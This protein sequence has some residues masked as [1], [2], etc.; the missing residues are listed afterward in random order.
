MPHALRLSVFRRLLPVLALLFSA[1]P[2]LTQTFP[3][4]PA[5]PP[6]NLQ[7]TALRDW[8]RTNWYDG[9]RTVLSYSAARA[10]L[11]NYVDNE[12]NKVR[13][14]YSGYEEARP[15]SFSSTSTTMQSLNCE[16]TVP[17]SWFDEVERMRSDIHHL[18]P[19]VVQWNS[20]RG[21]DPFAEIPDAQTTKW[22]RLL[23]SQSSI[24]GSNLGE[25]SEDTNSQ[26]EPRDDHKG[27]LARAVFYFYTMH[28]GQTFDAGKGVITALGSLNMLY[29]WHLQDPVD[30]HEQERNRRAAASQG[31]YNP[32][33]NDPALVARAWGFVAAGDP[34][35]QFAAAT[36]SQPEGNTGSSSYQLTVTLTAAPAATVTVQVATDAAGSTATAGPD[37]TFTSPQTLTFGPSLPTSQTL[38]VTVLGDATVE[39]DETLRLR[40]QNLSGPATLG[41]P[42]THDLTILN[43][44]AA[45]GTTTLAFAAAS[46]S[47]LEGNS[48][49]STYTVN[50]TLTPAAS[51]TVTVPV[52]VDA[53]SSSADAADFTLGTRADL[54]A[55]QRH[56][57]G[58]RRG[59]ARR[60]AAAAAGPAHGP[61]HR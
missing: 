51:G 25:W 19:A 47:Q 53:A 54:A 45:A 32:Y 28:S 22:I 17:Q 42:A 7:G 39:P 49:S 5:A 1:L 35:V 31:N 21:S 14:V 20:D 12:Q 27:N 55:S 13:C 9:K 52:E 60:A 56:G 6:T 37:Y 41:T 34:T 29:Q 40:L 48:G 36:G 30:A 11:Y 4:V 15:L 59:G 57:A 23:A 44:D 3:A 10:K 61:G 2:G 26:F 24:P 50:V 43:D 46:G 8:L 33:I 18:F 58:R 16:H 38:T